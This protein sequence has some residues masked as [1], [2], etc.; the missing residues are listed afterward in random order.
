MVFDQ[1]KL[2]N[3][4]IE[5]QRELEKTLFDVDELQQK[6]FKGNFEKYFEARLDFD[7][8]NKIMDD[9]MK[10]KMKNIKQR[11]EQIED[12]EDDEPSLEFEMPLEE[13]GTKL[14]KINP[15]NS[16]LYQ[17]SF[18]WTIALM[19][20]LEI[21]YNNPEKQNKDSYRALTNCTL[22]CAKIAY[23]GFMPAEDFE[24]SFEPLDSEVSRDG[25]QL[26]KI[27]LQRTLESLNNLL[28]YPNYDEAYLD[29]FILIG[30]QIH[31]QITDIL[32][33]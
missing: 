31:K 17:A 10:D 1:P 33:N 21:Q 13:M 12:F 24:S 11:K 29:K 14:S 18:S 8:Y 2:K 32:Y 25:L 26:A 15:Q 5:V 28:N 22:V 16:D 27:F 7:K 6:I 4:E 3:Y 19:R 9:Y 30:Q 20:W 23:A